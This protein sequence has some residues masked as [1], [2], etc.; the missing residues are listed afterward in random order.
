[1]GTSCQRRDLKAGHTKQESFAAPSPPISG[2]KREPQGWLDVAD[3]PPARPTMEMETDSLLWREV[4]AGD[5]CFWAF[6][7][8]LS[9][10]PHPSL[11]VQG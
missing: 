6:Q 2:R 5:S 7:H 8:L 9:V 10:Y 3:C 11:S 1:M 4:A